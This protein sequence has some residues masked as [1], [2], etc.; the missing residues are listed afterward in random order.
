MPISHAFPH[1][2]SS[3]LIYQVVVAPT[4]LHLGAVQATL[5]AP[6]LV[7]AQNCS[8]SGNG[9]FTGEVSADMLKDHGVQWVILGHSE[10]R[11]L[12]GES[13]ALVGQKTK[14]AL[15]KGLAVIACIG[16]TLDE[17]KADQTLAVCVRQL[18]AIGANVAPAEWSRIVIA[19]VL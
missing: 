4:N 18:A 16:E 11:Q 13:D 15:A 14:V 6:A 3:S 7:A 17:R 10:R 1:R 5:A 2:L 8:V 12:Y 9:A 19:Y